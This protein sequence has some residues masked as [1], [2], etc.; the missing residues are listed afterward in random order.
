MGIMPLKNGVYDIDSDFFRKCDFDDY[1]SMTFG[2]DYRKRTRNQRVVDMV[3]TILP[4]EAIRNFFLK[5]CADALDGRIPNTKFVLMIGE[6]A[7]NGEDKFDQLDEN[8]VWQALCHN[9]SKRF[10]GQR[11][12]CPQSNMSFGKAKEHEISLF[13]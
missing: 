5:C 10:D 4:V 12:G 6:S 9:Q 13:V 1:V 11:S 8:D 2:Y 7:L 3:N